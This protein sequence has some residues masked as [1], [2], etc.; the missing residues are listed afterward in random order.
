MKTIYCTRRIPEN[1]IQIMRD[2]GYSVDVGDKVDAP[3]KEELIIALSQKAYD[4][5]VC[6]LTDP[7]DKDIYDAC[8]SAKIFAQYSVGFN[9]IDVE[10]AKSRN[11]T[12]TNTPGSSSRAVAEHAVMLMLALT[13]RAVEGDAFM[14]S[15]KYTG[16]SPY[17]LNGTDL[18][19]KTIGLLGCGAIGQEVAAILHGGFACPIIYNDINRSQQLEDTCSAMFVDRET[20]LR[21]SDIVSLHVPLLP[22]TEHLINKETLS[23]MKKSSYLINTAR[24]KVVDET[25]LVSALTEGVIAGAGLD[26]YELEP[27]VA[28]GLLRMSSVVL[29]PHIASARESVRSKM[30]EIVGNNIVS[31]FETG[32]ALNEVK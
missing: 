18:T 19:G 27:K 21:T 32:K 3:T 7:I 4:G 24:G 30:A 6:F 15:G 8:P 31:F 9:N 13:T 20:L 10:E 16:W 17:L 12:I 29:T 22:S 25:A 2:K 23:Q 1:G 28:D 5:V 26:V 14:R 11:I